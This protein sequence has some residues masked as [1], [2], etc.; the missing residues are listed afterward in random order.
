M[1]MDLKAADNRAAGMEA[2]QAIE[3]A[4]LYVSNVLA[5][6]INMMSIPSPTNFKAERGQDRRRQVLADR[7]RHQ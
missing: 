4:A 7:P 1:S 6:R 2:D 5:N 3:G